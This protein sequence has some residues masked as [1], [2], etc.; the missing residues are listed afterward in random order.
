[1]ADIRGRVGQADVDYAT[2][3]Q[4]IVSKLDHKLFECPICKE[5]LCDAV[6]T[7]CGHLFCANCYHLGTVASISVLPNGYS[8]TASKECPVCRQQS[9]VVLRS[10]N[11][12]QILVAIY[13]EEYKK[14]AESLVTDRLGRELLPEI[15]KRVRQEL[16]KKLREELE[17]TIRQELQAHPLPIGHEP[18]IVVTAQPHRAFLGTI[19]TYIGDP[20]PHPME[21]QGRWRIWFYNAILWLASGDSNCTDHRVGP[22]PISPT[23][24]QL[25]RRACYLSCVR[26]SHA[27]VT[28]FG[29]MAPVATFMVLR[30]LRKH[31]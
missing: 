2:H 24:W 22:M 7:E 27:G 23:I 19:H 21:G 16:E 8:V 20:L 14:R 26:V 10:K 15:E 12:E 25:V 29:M 6:M 31:T 9:R 28:A 17:P 30:Y 5:L 11:L 4:S 3:L 1:M 13:P 18:D